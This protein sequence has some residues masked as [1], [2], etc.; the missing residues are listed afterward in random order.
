MLQHDKVVEEVAKGLERA[1]WTTVVEKSFPTSVGNRKPDITAT[2][3]GRVVVVDAQVIS[4]EEDLEVLHRRK[5]SKYRDLSDLT[6]AVTS[7][8]GATSTTSFT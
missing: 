5:V 6:D 8:H 3:S 4:S 7:F 2:R 1:G